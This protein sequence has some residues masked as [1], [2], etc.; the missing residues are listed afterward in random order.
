MGRNGF[1]HGAP[2]RPSSQPH[3]R[4]FRRYRH[5]QKE[6]EEASG[7]L[8]LLIVV[9][10]RNQSPVEGRISS[11]IDRCRYPCTQQVNKQPDMDCCTIDTPSI[12]IDK[13]KRP[14]FFLSS[15]EREKERKKR[16]KTCVIQGRSMSPGHQIG[17]GDNATAD[18]CIFPYI[19]DTKFFLAIVLS[20]SSL[21]CSSCRCANVPRPTR[22]RCSRSLSVLP[23]VSPMI[24]YK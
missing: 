10:Y 14:K 19:I 9:V 4:F 20:S 24:K 17:K 2:S 6:P 11:S 12:P 15:F 1:A 7:L 21:F 22:T 8:L 3:R 16:G 18:N 13:K 5:K 23:S